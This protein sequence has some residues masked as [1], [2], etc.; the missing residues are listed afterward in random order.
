MGDKA[1]TGCEKIIYPVKVPSNSIE[2]RMEFFY[3]HATSYC[4]KYIWKSKKLEM[5]ES[6]VEA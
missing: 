1:Y 3:Q 2:K 4:G 6:R 5:L